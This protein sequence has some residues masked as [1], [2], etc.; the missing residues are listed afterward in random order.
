MAKTSPE[1]HLRTRRAWH[2]TRWPGD[3]DTALGRRVRVPKFVDRGTPRRAPE[4]GHRTIHYT[5]PDS[6]RRRA[7]A[8]VHLDRSSWFDPRR[9][10]IRRPDGLLVAEPRRMLFLAI[11][12]IR[13]GTGT[14]VVPEGRRRSAPRSPPRPRCG[15][16]RLAGTASRRTIPAR[17][18]DRRP[19][20][21]GR[22][23]AAPARTRRLMRP[24]T[25]AIGP[26][27]RVRSRRFR[28]VAGGV[29]A[30]GG[31]LGSR[32]GGWVPCRGERVLSGWWSGSVERC[33]ANLR[34]HLWMIR[35]RRHPPRSI[36]TL[37]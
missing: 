37:R 6:Y 24:E 3:G 11:D 27:W 35:F 21:R 30:S 18:L 7:P 17:S 20:R 34:W 9:D 32:V 15:G 13:G 22:P 14:F 31:V 2:G 28:V 33:F 1:P 16:G 4:D 10:R 23:P 5:V 26:A 29:L 36:G 25:L 12:Q 8:D 19:P